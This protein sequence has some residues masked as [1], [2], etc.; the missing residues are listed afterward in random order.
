ML[1]M[2]GTLIE[3]E[4]LAVISDRLDA[5][6]ARAPYSLSAAFAWQDGDQDGGEARGAAT[7]RWKGFSGQCT[8]GDVSDSKDWAP[9]TLTN[10]S[11]S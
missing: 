2:I 8:S 11:L 1:V 10:Y 7:R 3:Q 5:A 4:D 9:T 6:R